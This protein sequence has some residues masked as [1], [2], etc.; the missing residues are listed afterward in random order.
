MQIEILQLIL[1]IFIGV[2]SITIIIPFLTFPNHGIRNSKIK[3]TKEIEHLTKKLSGRT[4]EETL[5][6]VFKYITR[7]YE[8]GDKKYKLILYPSHYL[9][10]IKKLLNKKFLACHQQNILLTNLLINSNKF[11]RKDIIKKES[12][13]L[14]LTIHQSLII[15][16]DK[17]KFK[18]DPFFNILQPIQNS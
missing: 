12:V 2:I 16:I 1:G 7:N 11:K 5:S 3:K 13:T 9:Q 10:N 14:F 15:N 6:K 8:G 17:K 18:V 4:Q